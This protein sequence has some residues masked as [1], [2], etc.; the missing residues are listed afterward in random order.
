M[1]QQSLE[2]L[3]VLPQDKF[4]IILIIINIKD[5]KDKGLNKP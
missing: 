3:Q 2:V 1:I 4:I 5:Y